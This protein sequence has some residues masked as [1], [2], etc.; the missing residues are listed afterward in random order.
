MDATAF[1][2]AWNHVIASNPCLR[3]VFC[4]VESTNLQVVL[5]SAPLVVRQLDL[6]SLSTAARVDAIER[7]KAEDLGS[8]FDLE[9]GPL[10][11]VALIRYADD[12]FALFW[13]LAIRFTCSQ[14]IALGYHI[15]CLWHGT[16]GAVDTDQ[17]LV[18]VR[19]KWHAV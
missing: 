7:I 12:H 5:E 4:T 10:L 1:E 11:R 2:A 16:L 8:S 14:G 6:S 17:W 13:A 3:S 15:L 19:N 9:R 18:R